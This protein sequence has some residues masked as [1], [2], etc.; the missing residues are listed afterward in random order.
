M[1]V[2]C[3]FHLLLLPLFSL[4]CFSTDVIDFQQCDRQCRYQFGFYDRFINGIRVGA[5]D[6]HDKLGRHCDC[7]K[8]HTKIGNVLRSSFKSWNDADF[9]CGPGGNGTNTGFNTT[10]VCVQDPYDPNKNNVKTATRK[11]AVSNHWNVVHCGKC[12]ACSRP[13]DIRVLYD[14]RHTITTDM[15]RCAAKFAKPKF[16]GGDPDLE[17]LKKCL[18]EANITF[19]DVFKLNTTTNEGNGPTCMEC[20]TDN[21]MC[22]STQCNTD[23][24]CIE[25]F[26]NPNNT[27]AFSGCLKCDE[28]H[29]GS[30]FIQCAGANR[31]SSGII[32][33]I[34][35]V[36][37]QVCHVGWYWKCSQCHA[38]CQKGDVSCNAKCEQLQSCRGPSFTAVNEDKV[39]DKDKDNDE[40]GVNY[41]DENGIDSTTNNSN[42]HPQCMYD[43]SPTWSTHRQ[44][45]YMTECNSS[46][47]AQQW[48]GDTFE[49][50][51]E[52]PTSLPSTVQNGLWKDGC[53][54]TS[55]NEP[56]YV[57]T[58]CDGATFLYNTTNLT[59]SV[60]HASPGT[61]SGKGVG[62]CMDIDGGARCNAIDLWS[63]HPTTN[64]D[65]KHQ[66]FTYNSASKTFTSPNV[67]GHE[68]CLSLNRTLLAPYVVTPCIWPNVLPVE[69]SSTHRTD[70]NNGNNGNN[71]GPPT[72]SI[73]FAGGILLHDNITSIPQYG[74]DT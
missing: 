23:P 35:R 33:D 32:S 43:R 6:H 54:S 72:Q 22:D 55:I 8:N 41:D 57:A 71:V 39:K 28:K 62:A 51:F 56:L 7:Y 46:D 15:T 40:N 34:A 13:S 27:G 38:K 45:V 10:L 67:C 11:Q 30:E 44:Y 25:K 53:L 2:S 47:P 68:M 64:R 70:Y 69:H 19:D 12:S 16:L 26:I 66:Q 49:N 24:S 21:I 29:C 61:E 65:Y 18:R 17:H 73:L 42:Q 59:L 58:P 60:Y 3:S 37:D 52:N 74:A 63:C 5:L 1:R 50:T 9:W 36:G 31:R 48:Y 4:P 20:W 14:T